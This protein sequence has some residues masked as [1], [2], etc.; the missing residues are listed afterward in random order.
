MIYLKKSQPAPECL[1]SEKEK[2]SGDYKC[3]NVLERL[4]NDFKNK[5]YICEYK[6]PT[7]INVEHFV[8]HKE[9]KELKFDWDNLF[10][11]CGHCNN[12]KLAKFVNILNCI[13]ELDNVE[14]DLRYAFEPL[15]FEL[16]S[17]E[18]LKDD[19]RVINTR[20]LL[21][22]VYNG[23]TPLKLIESSNLRD[24][25]L[26]EII[27]FRKFLINYFKY[28]DSEEDREYHLVRIKA[29]LNKDSSFTAFKR[30]IIRNNEKLFEIFGEYID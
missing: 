15:P 7:T 29:H 6:K 8:P 24:K 18:A 14:T 2:K 25:L 1:E 26:D 3:G 23:T 16:V 12:I 11:A 22:A 28:G 5:C 13:V 4:K 30:W 21:L 27:D 20:E 10:W 17:I 9:D 19:E